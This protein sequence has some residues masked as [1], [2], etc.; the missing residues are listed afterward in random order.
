MNDWA[1]DLSR[2]ET[3]NALAYW[4]SIR[5]ERAMPT[6]R[7]LSPRG[8]RE[9]LPYVNLVDV[10]PATEGASSHYQISLESAH[11]RNVFGNLAIHSIIKSTSPERVRRASECFELVRKAGR[12]A[13][14]DSRV[15]VRGQFWLD[16]ESLLAPLGD[17]D[18]QVTAIMWVFVSWTVAAQNQAHP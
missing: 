8:M 9:F 13:H 14:V 1:L 15:T 10:Q 16:S 7:E 12:P 11:T 5:G 2:P 6:R 17:R 3:K 18:G 4:G